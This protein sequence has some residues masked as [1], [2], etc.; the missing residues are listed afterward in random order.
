MIEAALGGCSLKPRSRQAA[1]AWGIVALAGTQFII[2]WLAEPEARPMLQ[3]PLGLVGLVA[4]GLFVWQLSPPRPV[5]PEWRPLTRA[6]GGLA[7]LAIAGLV[8]FLLAAL[9]WVGRF[10]RAF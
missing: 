5:P 6:G 7:L 9:Y 10:A 2:L 4:V 1:I 8:A 3:L